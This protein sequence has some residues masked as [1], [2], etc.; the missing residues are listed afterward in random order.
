MNSTDCKILTY[1]NPFIPGSQS[2]GVLSNSG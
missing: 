2:L 1:K